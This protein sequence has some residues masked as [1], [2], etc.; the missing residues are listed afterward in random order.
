MMEHIHPEPTTSHTHPQPLNHSLSEHLSLFHILSQ[1][2]QIAFP[3]PI[4]SAFRFSTKQNVKKR[5]D[6]AARG[7]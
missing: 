3:N 7:H 2:Y 4:N 5:V 6:V 1:K